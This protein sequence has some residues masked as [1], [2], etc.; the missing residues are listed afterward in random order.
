MGLALNT[1]IHSRKGDW[2]AEIKGWSITDCAVRS[3]TL[4]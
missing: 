4:L 2:E 3:R 1:S